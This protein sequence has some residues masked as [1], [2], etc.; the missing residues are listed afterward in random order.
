[1]SNK[2]EKSTDHKKFYEQA[3]PVSGFLGGLTFTAM[4]VLIQS[5]DKFSSPITIFPLLS[6]DYYQILIAAMAVISV[7]FITSAVGMINIASGIRSKGTYVTTMD[8][9]MTLGFYGLLIFLPMIVIP[10]SV[11][12]AAI[13]ITIEIIYI[14]IFVRYK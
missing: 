1:M 4:T 9:L 7:L 3:I 8:L 14:T 5:K 13:V 10:F 11:I 6:L 12:G 2:R